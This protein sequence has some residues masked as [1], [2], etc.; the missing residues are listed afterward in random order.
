M[1]YNCH[2]GYDFFVAIDE[3]GLQ[4]AVHNVQ[5]TKGQV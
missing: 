2:S 1:Y 3:G 4:M 5:Y